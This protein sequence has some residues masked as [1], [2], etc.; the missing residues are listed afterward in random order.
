[1]KKKAI[2]FIVLTCFI[3]GLIITL[4]SRVG[5]ADPPDASAYEA[6]PP[7]LAASVP[8]LVMLVMGRDHKL[9]YEA[10]N[11]ATDLDEDGEL[12]T[13]Y[14]PDQIDYYG[15]FDS[16]KYYSYS[17]TN[18]RF[19]PEGVTS[20][21]KTP[22]GYWSGDFLNYLTM[23]RI[24]VL[25]K[26]LYG[27]YRSVDTATQTVLERA[28]IPN[29]A[30]CWGKEY[31]NEATD[32][33]KISDYT[34]YSEPSTG[35]RHLFASG[36]VVAP[37]SSSYAPL[38]RVKL[39]SASRIW[40][41]VS[42]ESGNG[43]LGTSLV[44][45][46]DD[47]FDVRV[48]V[49]VSSFPDTEG[50]KQYGTGSGI[51]YKPVGILQRYGESDRI[52]F[53]LISGSYGNHLSG[54]VLRKNISSIT[55]E[56]NSSTGQFN[57][58]TD[59]TIGGI[60][61]TIDNFRIIGFSH[62]SHYWD[63]TTYAGP[64]SEG[65][66]YMWGNP[67]AEMMYESLRYF[68]GETK[69]AGFSSSVSDGNDRGLDLPM[70]TWVDPYTIFPSCSKPIM[71]VLSDINPSYDTDQLPGSYFGGS[72]GLGTLNVQTEAG[73]I[74]TNEGFSGT[75]EH[76]I[77]QSGGY[78]DSACSAKGISGLGEIRGLCPEEP[79][80][81]GG[82]YAASVAYYGL[83]TD[84]STVS[85]NQTVS[86]YSVGLASPLPRIEI[87]MDDSQ[88]ITLVPFA[89]T[90]YSTSGG[91]V[92]PDRG[93]FQPTCAIV[94]FYVDSIT[95]T[96]GK[97]RV[98]YEHAEQG[99]D[100]DMDAMITYEYEKTSGTTIEVTISSKEATY[101]GGSKQH[102]GYIIS[103]TDADG[104]YLEIKNDTQSD[105][106]DRDYYLDTPGTCGPNEGE[107]D[108]CW[109][110]NTHLPDE[111]TRE[112]SVGTASAA[113][114]LENPL[115]YAAKYGGF[116][117][118][119][120][121][122][123][124]DQQ[125]EWDKDGDGVPDTYFY[126]INPLEL[127]AQLNKSFAA[128][129][130]E[131]ASGTAASVLANNS[132]GDSSLIQAFFK[133]TLDTPSGN[134]LTWLG[135]MQSLWVDSWGNIREDTNGNHKMD[136]ANV[137]AIT[138]GE[139]GNVDMIIEYAVDDEGDTV[140]HRYTSHHLYHPS[141]QSSSDC[142]L[143]LLGYTCPDLDN[144]YDTISLDEVEPIYEVGKMLAQRNADDRQIFTFIDGNGVD[145]DTD[146]TIDE[147]GEEEV[148][149]AKWVGQ[150]TDALNDDPFLTGGSDEVIPF[151]T[152]N[153]ERIKPFLGVKDATAWSYLDNAA[154]PSQEN[155]VKNLIDF[156]RGKDSADL[157]G[158]PDTRSRTLDDGTVWKLGDIVNSTPVSISDPPDSY[159]LIYGDESFQNY[160]NH[161]KDRETVVYVGANDGM[162][163]AFTSWEYDSDTETYTQ[164][165]LTIEELGDELWAY[166]PQALLPHLK[167]LADPEYAHSYYVDMKPK[168]FDAQ[169]LDDNSHYTDSDSNA[170]W[171]TILLVGLNMGGKQI[172]A[173]DDFDDDSSTDEK[174]YFNPTYICMDVTDP[175]N[176]RLL[177]ERSYQGL[178]MTASSPA[179]IA[180]GK[181]RTLSGNTYGWSVG[182]WL[183]V[184]G[185]GPT[186]YDGTS[187]Q[188]GYIF[189]VDVKT[190]EPYM[191]SDGHEWL[192]NTGSGAT[193][194][195]SPVAFDNN[196]TY[197]VDG[198]YFG[199]IIGTSG[200]KVF[201]VNTHGTD[202]SPSDNPT[203]WSMYSMFDAQ[204]PIS[205][206]ISLSTDS[207]DNVWTFFGTG[208]YLSTSDKSNTDQQ[209]F[210]GVKDPDYSSGSAVELTMADLFDASPYS[211][212][213]NQT[214][215]NSDDGSTS[216]WSSLTS[217]ARNKAGWYHELETL[218]GN[219]S[220]RVISKATV[221]GGIVFFPG[222]TPNT[223]ICGF[224][225]DT[226]YYGL[227]YETGTAYYKQ[228]L[229]GAT[230]TDTNG[231][232]VNASYAAGYG[233]PPP[234]AGF[235][236]GRESGA[237]AFLQMSTGEVIEIDV[238]TA[239][240]IKSNITGW[241]DKNK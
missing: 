105:S 30:H 51:V 138:S 32:G 95:S 27:G 57:Y 188:N 171:G 17:T 85:G 206:T 211:V 170:D 150:V 64:I 177:W 72:G 194:M 236:I 89:K 155:R 26:V 190:G 20:D 73:L 54:G 8:P 148:S 62:S 117:K 196:L 59:S 128:I 176:P 120:N 96:N 226:N 67:V 77:G 199:S 76:Y 63:Y 10:Y 191:S 47:D 166:I 119:N 201:K 239:F 146:G 86:T 74:S 133:P 228:V 104:V 124:P 221:L 143:D 79:T 184:F 6:Y 102:F 189:A 83:K 39:N 49:G 88:S 205:A 156:I 5:L 218:S 28:Y 84:L 172:W 99:S 118:K 175:R 174:R 224:N 65:Q 217:T 137:T 202:G 185:S 149:N 125:E 1:M 161:Y 40:T 134:T 55:D 173:E 87:P 45:T 237:T 232:M 235:H 81:M 241:R 106:E 68:A 60:I 53:G 168:L 61:K 222:Y 240:S 160:L 22:G 43:I 116:N 212:Y 21:K 98:T 219:P 197:N 108:T 181:E 144:S 145:D 3:S 169:I 123:T 16:F 107:L 223:D 216:T 71:L 18:K 151:S 132:E 229:P 208:R 183:A 238:E 234:A 69:T 195:N 220:E 153:W 75:S 101:G 140:V 9:Y 129:L 24:D 82:Y 182:K 122:D 29:D 112:F 231:E 41:W 33:Y 154:S 14:K 52:Y 94:D 111:K 2:I 121:N 50:E 187:D 35:T 37:E 136:Q 210:F 34:P 141:N 164:P 38:L 159:H 135:Y 126:V 80:K 91:G 225:G 180:V 44:G 46:P 110:D 4:S 157:T 227:Y 158:S 70:E 11:D 109:D 100:Y 163:H 19:E 58:K 130:E 114:L 165:S 139:T 92:T 12:D 56:I 131:T 93:D 90:V 97:F 207:Y 198:V 115:F 213:T 36:A 178:A 200:G 215:S 42:A 25:R 66:D 204:G 15:Y 162:L 233:A 193:S 31:T 179:I 209:Y 186:E 13:T 7:F 147:S 127:E 142:V 230:T 23:S 214:V 78:T 192:F 152:T 167:F 113:T 203:D 103:G 48:E